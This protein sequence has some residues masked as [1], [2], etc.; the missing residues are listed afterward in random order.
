MERHVNEGLNSWFTSQK[1]DEIMSRRKTFVRWLMMYTILTVTL[2]A[3]TVLVVSLFVTY[4][5]TSSLGNPSFFDAFPWIL[6]I[7]GCCL[8]IVGSAGNLPSR[9]REE[10]L[11]TDRAIAWSYIL[12]GGFLRRHASRYDWLLIFTGITQMVI[13]LYLLFAWNI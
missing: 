6:L 7:E 11:R 8:A 3:L 9:G 4:A 2:F 13:A 5:N 10:D 1:L 12:L